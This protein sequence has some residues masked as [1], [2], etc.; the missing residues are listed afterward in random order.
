VDKT[1]EKEAKKMGT[2]PIFPEY[3]HFLV[4]EKWGLSPFSIKLR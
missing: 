3:L 4:R 2:G 1:L